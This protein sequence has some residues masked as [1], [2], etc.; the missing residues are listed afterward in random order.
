[1]HLEEVGLG[2]KFFDNDAGAGVFRGETVW[3]ALVAVRFATR[4]TRAIAF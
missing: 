4:T 3:R 1:L 2:E